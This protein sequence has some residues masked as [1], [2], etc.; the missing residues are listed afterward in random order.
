MNETAQ[1]SEKPPSRSKMQTRTSFSYQRR[2]R[3]SEAAAMLTHSDRQSEIRA[4]VASLNDERHQLARVADFNGGRQLIQ[5]SF[6]IL[7]ALEFQLMHHGI[8]QSKSGALSSSLPLSSTII[9]LS[10]GNCRTTASIFSL[11]LEILIRRELIVSRKIY[12]ILQSV[13][14]MAESGADGYTNSSESNEGRINSYWDST[15]K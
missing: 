5:V 12:F 9:F 14:L 4:R 6:C 1:E 2:R 10:H 13:V 7:L 11:Y 8:P 3:E 15:P